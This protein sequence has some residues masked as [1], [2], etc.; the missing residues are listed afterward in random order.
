MKKKG[1]REEERYDNKKR[2]KMDKR[3]TILSYIFQ[4][5]SLIFNIVSIFSI[6]VFELFPSM[7]FSIFSHCS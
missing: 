3:K 5:I 2:M 7:I 1:K 4:S 6:S